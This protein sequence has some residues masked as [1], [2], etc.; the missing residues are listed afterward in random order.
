LSNTGGFRISCENVPGKLNSVESFSRGNRGQKPDMPKTTSI[1]FSFLAL[2]MGFASIDAAEGDAFAKIL[3]PAFAQSCVKCHGKGPK[4]KGKVNLFE[5]KSV[6]DLAEK[7]ELLSKL[8]EAL[9]SE[10][11]PPETEPARAP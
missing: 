9:D 6:S 3:Q 7:P 5:L 8:I 1:V 4:V 11:R 10:E 2:W